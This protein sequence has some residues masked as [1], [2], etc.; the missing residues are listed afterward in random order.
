MKYGQS[1]K[2]V[3]AVT[4][5]IHILLIANPYPYHSV[6]ITFNDEIASNARISW[7]TI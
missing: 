7:L 5:S 3:A 6:R 4:L 1:R 2:Q